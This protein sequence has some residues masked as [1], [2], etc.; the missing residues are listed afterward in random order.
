MPE[1]S[2]W[3]REDMAHKAEIIYY[4]AFHRKSLPT[5]ILEDSPFNIIYALLNQ[6]P[7]IVEEN[8]KSWAFFTPGM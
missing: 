6:N 1:L 7:I 8:G 5:H 2:P 3:D 4:L